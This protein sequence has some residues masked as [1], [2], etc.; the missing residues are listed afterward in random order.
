MKVAV[1]LVA[2]SNKLDGGCRSIEVSSSLYLTPTITLFE[3]GT[4]PKTITHLSQ[5][6]SKFSCES[7]LIFTVANPLGNS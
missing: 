5:I 6:I 4:Q 1:L 7:R 3:S 2:V